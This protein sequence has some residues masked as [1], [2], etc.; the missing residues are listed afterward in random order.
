[1]C[2]VGCVGGCARAYVCVCVADGGGWLGKGQCHIPGRG[3]RRSPL[4]ATALS[5]VQ[6]PLPITV[7]FKRSRLAFY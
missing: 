2:V 1:V 6:A 5:T 3:L 4:I 7:E